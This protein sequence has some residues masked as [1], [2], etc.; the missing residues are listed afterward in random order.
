MI[1]EWNQTRGV[2]RGVSSVDLDLSYV[3]DWKGL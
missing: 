2:S 3:A 1:R